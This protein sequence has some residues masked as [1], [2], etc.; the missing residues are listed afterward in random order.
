[1][2]AHAC[3]SVL[4]SRY[5]VEAANRAERELAAAAQGPGK[6]GKSKGHGEEKA[7]L[8]WHLERR[9]RAGSAAPHQVI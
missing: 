7:P 2:D 4:A 5:A 8:V 9:G 3:R 1:M 6:E